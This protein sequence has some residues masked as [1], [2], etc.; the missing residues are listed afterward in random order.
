MALGVS[1]KELDGNSTHSDFSL[2]DSSGVRF[3][4]EHRFD[5]E[6][7]SGPFVGNQM[8]DDLI[9]DQRRCSPILCDEGEHPV[10]AAATLEPNGAYSSNRGQGC[11][12]GCLNV[13][14]RVVEKSP[15]SIYDFVR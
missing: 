12:G 11:S 5:L 9:A 14:C 6:S 2:F 8:D 13:S 15:E 3:S 4:G 7:G 1:Q 10:L